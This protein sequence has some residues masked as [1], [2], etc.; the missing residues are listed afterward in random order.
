MVK[1]KKE[2]NKLE[3]LKKIFTKTKKKDKV[4]GKAIH[5]PSG[6]KKR[7]VVKLRRYNPGEEDIYP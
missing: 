4:K 1:K 5:F 2:K 3:K 6:W 7:T